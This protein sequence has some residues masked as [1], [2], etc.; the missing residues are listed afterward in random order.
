MKVADG[1]AREA[2]HSESPVGSSNH[3][4]SVFSHGLGI[5]S[6]VLSISFGILRVV[7]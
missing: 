1:Q 7:S 6:K 3:S 2:Y 4:L 5:V